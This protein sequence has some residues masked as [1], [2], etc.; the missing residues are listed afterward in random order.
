MPSMLEN[1][2]CPHCGHR[3]LEM[4][5][6]PTGL[7]CPGCN[8]RVEM[9]DVLKNI[10]E[11]YRPDY[12]SPFGRGSN[13]IQP[14]GR[15]MEIPDD[16]RKSLYFKTF[17]IGFVA[18]AIFYTC[19]S[20]FFPLKSVPWI[21]LIGLLVASRIADIISTKIVLALGGVET[22]PLSDP[23]DISKLISLQVFQVLISVGISFLLGLINP[24]LKNGFLIVFSLI[25]FEAFFANL[26]QVFAGP[27]SSVSKMSSRL[28]TAHVISIILVAA[29]ALVLLRIIF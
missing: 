20:F 6:S 22:N 28:Y 12:Q 27:L 3:G 7:Y 9:A 13:L 14:L 18:F 15:Q 8:E 2:V 4:A 21:F 1:M 29:I 19:S 24:W 5:S 16:E 23:H 10:Q 17:L 26:G 25:G 11:N